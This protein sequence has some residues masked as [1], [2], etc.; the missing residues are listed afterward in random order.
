MING[1]NIRVFLADGS[2]AGIVYAEIVNWTG[3]IILFPRSKLS[4]F[5]KQ[6]YEKSGIYFLI[7]D[8]L[9]QV[10]IGE[11]DNI[12][13]RLFEHERT[14]DFWDRVC[15]VVSKDQNLTKSHIRY[16]ENK[17]LSLAKDNEIYTLENG[18][19]GSLTIMQLPRADVA[20][21]EYFLSQIEMILPVLGLNFLK[22]GKM[23]RA[24]V[25]KNMSKN[26]QSDVIGEFQL[27]AKGLT[28]FAQEINGEFIVLKG[29]Q[30]STTITESGKTNSYLLNLRPTL[31]DKGII[32]SETY[33]F[34]ED[35][36]FNS[37]SAAAAIISGRFANGRTMWKLKSD[38][39]KTYAD[40]Q[41]EREEK[42][43]PL[44]ESN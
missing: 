15:I 5:N 35:Y 38:L 14:K 31:L 30:V 39:S 34:M 16:L 32:D 36:K 42:I 8:D 3:E 21:M 20:D 33:T 24:N 4:E 27:N 2:I 13:R 43:L 22:T 1:K 11:T 44:I 9:K 17:L 18:N 23:S 29:S 7:N 6:E 28:A 41:N 19:N 10:Y 26:D 12:S 37:P 40:W 25:I